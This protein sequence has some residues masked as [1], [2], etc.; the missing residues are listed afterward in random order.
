M[1]SYF[2]T[3]GTAKKITDSLGD[4]TRISQYQSYKRGVDPRSGNQIGCDSTGK[5]RG[6]FGTDNSGD[7]VLAIS[8]SGQDVVNLLGL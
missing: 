1:K 2:L 3:T 8:A 7:F 5:R 6:F 4:T